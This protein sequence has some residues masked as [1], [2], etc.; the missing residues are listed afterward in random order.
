[1]SAVTA[2]RASTEDLASLA[3][4][5]DQWGTMVAE[6]K[7]N[8]AR[9]LFADD[10]FAFGTFMDFVDGLD[11]MA[12]KQWGAIW[13]TIEGFRF[14]TENLRAVVS[15]DRLSATAAVVW[16]STGIDRAGKRYDR[17]GRAT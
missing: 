7:P 1:M 5:F 10:V 3:G 14:V 2:N 15:K 4:W 16:T 8:S 11:S 6:V 13:P 9:T 17:P 12:E